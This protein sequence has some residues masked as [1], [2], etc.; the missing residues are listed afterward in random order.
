M[1]FVTTQRVAD[2][3]VSKKI[4]GEEG[5][6]E[7]VSYLD[8]L[9]IALDG[10]KDG[11]FAKGQ[12]GK[13][14]FLTVNHPLSKDVAKT[15]SL[16]Q[17]L[18]AMSNPKKAPTAKSG[19]GDAVA[20]VLTV[21]GIVVS[22]LGAPGIGLP[23]VV[24]GLAACGGSTLN[25]GDLC[26]PNGLCHENDSG[27]VV[28]GCKAPEVETKCEEMKTTSNGEGERPTGRYYPCCR[29]P[30]AGSGTSG[31]GECNSLRCL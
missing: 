7:L 29:T 21:G 28:C 19:A 26:P 24:L 2:A 30:Y 10:R 5:R 9:D 23:M 27:K 11:G 18:F 25:C 31:G 22:A 12:I 15:G 13:D 20:A 17:L 14:V 6:A 8:Q 4:V 16:N 3:A 1:E